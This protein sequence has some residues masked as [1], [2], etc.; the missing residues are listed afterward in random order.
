MAS[1]RGLSVATCYSYLRASSAKQE[2]SVS[3]QRKFVSPAITRKGWTLKATFEDD[4]VSAWK[5]K[6]REGFDLLLKA[7][8]DEPVDYVVVFLINRWSRQF[9]SGLQ[10]IIHLAT[11]GTKIYDAGKDKIYDVSNIGDLITLAV[12]LSEANA[13]SAN[14]SLAVQRGLD[15]YRERGGWHGQAPFGFI[16]ER[17]KDGVVVLKRHPEQAPIVEE[18]FAL[19]KDGWRL[20]EIAQHLNRN[21]HRTKQ[22]RPFRETYLFH[23]MKNPVFTGHQNNKGELRKVQVELYM[24]AELVRTVQ[25]NLTDKRTGTRRTTTKRPLTK[26]L[27]CG[28][29]GGPC[30]TLSGGRA[31]PLYRCSA[32]YTGSCDNRSTIRIQDIEEAV[33]ERYEALVLDVGFEE[34]I[35]NIVEEDMLRQKQMLKSVQP[36]LDKLDEISQHIESLIDLQIKSKNTD[37]IAKRID[38]L[39]V[40]REKWQVKLEDHGE[41]VQPISVEEATDRFWRDMADIRFD[42][43]LDR[44][45]DYIVIVGQDKVKL[46][47]LGDKEIEIKLPRVDHSTRS[48]KDIE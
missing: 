16:S 20:T 32:V 26:K 2:D 3:Q 37:A 12:E 41:E 40:E 15:E 13:Y 44:V 10:H 6:Q 23:F 43:G 36:I 38:K 29:C 47:L 19:Y 22:G 9:L 34:V 1:S 11:Q 33:Y 39:A 30:H 14:L 17:N 46:K 25:N 21:G 27:S 35:A 5:G 48:T 8:V 42:S 31:K 4:G 45:V 18:M 7:C 28:V 24:D